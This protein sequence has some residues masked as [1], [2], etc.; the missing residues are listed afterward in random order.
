[1]KIFLDTADLAEIER[2]ADANLIDG[3]TTNPSLLAKVAGAREP[4]EI[5]LD[6]CRAVDGPVSAEVVAVDAEGMVSEG[7]KLAAIHENIVVKV[8]LTEAGLQACRSLRAGGIRVNV[9]LCFSTTQAL[10]AAKAGATYISPFVGRLD[11][12]GHDGMD[13]VRDIRHVYDE[14]GLETE[15]LAAS[16]RHPRHVLEAML[17]GADCATLPSKVL[18]Q[19]MKHPLTDRGLEAFLSDWQS[20]G[21]QL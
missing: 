1:M 6:I 8:P 20:L 21:K 10:L 14:Y 15:I 19:C 13:I 16:L 4:E 11:D 17:I 18:Y 2:A 9:T 7:V 12:I 5:F 3:I